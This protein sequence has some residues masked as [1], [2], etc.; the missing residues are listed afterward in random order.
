MICRH[1]L[2]LAIHDVLVSFFFS[3]FGSSGILKHF[4]MTIIEELLDKAENA[5]GRGA[6]LI[7][8]SNSG[9]NSRHS[10]YLS[11][12]FGKAITFISGIQDKPVAVQICIG[13]IAGW[14]VFFLNLSD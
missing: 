10:N 8:R 12:T 4:R 13:S 5:V 11:N 9:E 1:Y 14:Q 3:F 2:L 6:K 7:T